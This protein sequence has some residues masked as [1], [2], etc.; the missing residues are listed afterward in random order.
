MEEIILNAMARSEKPKKVRSSGFIPGVLN[1]PGTTSAS[2]KFE[3]VALNKIIAKHGTNAKL[4]VVLGT[5]KTFGFIKEVQKHPVEGKIIHIGIQL[6]SKDQEVKMQ[7]PI[8]FHG[9]TELEHRLL[10]LQVY[11]PEIEVEG[12]TALMPDEVVVDVSEKKSG[13]TITASDFHLSSG[14]KILDPEDEI[15]AIIK[16]VKKESVEAPEEVKPAE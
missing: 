7:L 5:E 10:Q 2:V 16:A 12:K 4:W 13:E 14:V 8:T 1:G 9:H 11:K 6:V 15:Y 3:S